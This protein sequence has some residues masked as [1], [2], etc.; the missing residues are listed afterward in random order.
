VGL[1]QLGVQLEGELGDQ[2]VEE[3]EIVQCAMEMGP[4]LGISCGGDGKQLRDLL[5]S[6]D[7]EH[8]QE[9]SD[10]LSKRGTK[11]RRELKNLECSIK[12]EGSNCGKGKR[13]MS[14][15]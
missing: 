2:H 3:S 5:T 14:V 12:L 4:L 9:I 15:F 1:D 8:C 11:G 10:T 6:L 7:K 13:A